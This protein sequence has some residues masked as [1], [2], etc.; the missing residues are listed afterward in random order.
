MVGRSCLGEGQETRN[1]ACCKEGNVHNI[2]K[3][4]VVSEGVVDGMRKAQ[5]GLILRF[6]LAVLLALSG[7]LAGCMTASEQPPAPY[8][9]EATPALAPP[10][11]P[12]ALP[13]GAAPTAPP[14][15]D[16][17]G[18]TPDQARQVLPLP[19]L[20]LKVEERA[21]VPVISWSAAG[22]D[23]AYFAIYRRGAGRD[24]ELV[25]R[26]PAAAATGGQYQWQDSSAPAAATAVYGVA[27]VDIRGAGSEIATP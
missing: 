27:A 12:A 26:V 15:P 1:F 4:A 19:P 13:A 5:A 14:A 9:A 7:G 2:G 21:G 3:E 25:A 23:I 22:S 18:I 20:G 24:W 6:V 17:G 16:N 8:P 11:P 10:P